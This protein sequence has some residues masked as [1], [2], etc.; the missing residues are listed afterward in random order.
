MRLYTRPGSPFI[1]YD[2]TVAGDRLRG[3]SKCTT[4][5][6]AKVVVD[7]LIAEA[8][9]RRGTADAWRLR[10]LTGAYWNDIGQHRKSEID[11]WRYLECLNDII[12]PD[13]PVEELTTE[14][15]LDYRAKRRRHTTQG[16]SAVTVNRDL[17][18]LKAAL[19]HA[20]TAYRKPLPEIAWKTLMVREN[21]WRT[22]YASAAEFARLLALS[23]P[24]LRPMLIAAVTTGLRRGSIL[25]LQWHQVD[26][27]GGIITLPTTKSGKPHRVQMTG[28]LRAALATLQPEAD[29]RRGQVF[30][31]TGWRSRWRSLRI[32]AA[33]PDLRFHD[34]RHTFASWARLGGADLQGLMEALDHSSIAMTMRYSNI[35]PATG[36]TAFDKV[37]DL[38]TAQSTAQSPKK[39]RKSAI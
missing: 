5:R 29:L 23:H 32:K 9:N 26:M 22:R 6:E 1:W 24:S 16:C 30:D 38:L 20:H 17:A 19:N 10:E 36:S 31:T 4:R 8:R 33:V 15:L 25:T 39:P 7:A 21:P 14:L 35:K 34:L 3:S 27:D 18:T 12:G 28:P 13:K 11:I 37:A 2:V